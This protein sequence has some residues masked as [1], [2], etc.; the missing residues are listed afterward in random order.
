MS[1]AKR[2]SRIKLSENNVQMSVKLHPRNTPRDPSSDEPSGRF[3][4]NHR[5][6]TESPQSIQNA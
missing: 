4:I 6:N 1:T 3:A 5:A 2:Q